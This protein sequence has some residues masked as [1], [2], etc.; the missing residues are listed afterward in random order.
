MLPRVRHSGPSGWILAV[1]WAQ[2]QCCVSEEKD[3]GE[4]AIER[5]IERSIERPI[6]WGGG[7]YI[8][9]GNEMRRMSW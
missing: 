4:G 6:A 1:C 5:F 3:R 8:D 2:P 9:E 7:T